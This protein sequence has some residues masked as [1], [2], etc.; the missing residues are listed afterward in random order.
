MRFSYEEAELI[1]NMLDEDAVSKPNKNVLIN[2][3]DNIISED[4]ETIELKK[5]TIAKLNSLN[6]ST[7]KNMTLNLPVTTYELYE[8]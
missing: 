1:N 7:Y 5:S 3:I 6:E 2:L 4:T 8:N